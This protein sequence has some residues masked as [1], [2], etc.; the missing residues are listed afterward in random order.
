LDAG[1]KQ[2]AINNQTAY[3]RSAMAMLQNL[4]NVGGLI[5]F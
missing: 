2:N 4:A 1:A 3:L 5:T